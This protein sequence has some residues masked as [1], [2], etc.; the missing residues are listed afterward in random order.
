MDVDI[1]FETHSTSRD[2]ER[3]IASGWNDPVLSN[4]GREQARTLGARRKNDAFAVVFTSDLA[5]AVETAALAFAGSVVP[6]HQ[7]RRLRE[8][9]YGDLNG[10]HQRE[11][12]PRSRFVDLPFPNGESYRDVARRVA[13]FLSDLGVYRGRR[14]LVIGHTATCWSLQHLIDGTPLETLVA[15]PL[16]WREGWSFRYSP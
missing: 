5:R 14:V 12:E 13:S 9:N 3:G 11:L 10:T 6:I 8:C 16:A 7:D 15:G 2:N 1:V 4:V